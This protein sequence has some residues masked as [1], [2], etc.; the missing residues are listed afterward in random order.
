MKNDILNVVVLNPKYS[1]I[2]PHTPAITLFELDLY[3]MFDI[4]S[5]YL[6]KNI[7]QLFII[8]LILLYH[9][10]QFNSK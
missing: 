7:K 10:F 2:P 8:Y 4:K 6:M 9:Y 3:N 5:P 1:D